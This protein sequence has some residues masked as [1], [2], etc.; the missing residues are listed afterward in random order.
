MDFVVLDQDNTSIKIRVGDEHNINLMKSDKQNLLNVLSDL[1]NNRLGFMGIDLNTTAIEFTGVDFNSKD[2]SR[3]YWISF[4]G[5]EKY[6]GAKPFR[7]FIEKLIEL[8]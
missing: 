3:D 4:N 6:L 5:E 7:E 8:I 1:D 2:R